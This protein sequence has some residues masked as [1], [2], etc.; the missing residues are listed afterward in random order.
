LV[1]KEMAAKDIINDYEI[2]GKNLLKGYEEERQKALETDQAGLDQVKTAL[3]KVY[4]E[5]QANIRNTS[6]EST[7]RRTRGLETLEARRSEQEK[8]RSKAISAAF[9]ACVD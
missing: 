8:S 4:L 1:D 5:A 2:A 9:A 3:S 6:K 7:K